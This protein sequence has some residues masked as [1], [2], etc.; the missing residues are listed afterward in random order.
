MASKT[1]DV[2]ARGRWKIVIDQVSQ[3]LTNNTSKVRVRGIMYNDGSGTSADSTGNCKRSISGTNGWS[4]SSVNFSVSGGGSHTLIDRE[5]TVTHDNDGTKQVTYTAKFGPTITSTFGSGGSVTLSMF[6]TRIPR[7]PG[8]PTNLQTVF[9]AP[10]R[11]NI[12]WG[13]APDNGSPVTEYHI[14]YADNPGF[15]PSSTKVVGNVL[16]T[17]VEG[18]T[19]GKTWYFKVIPKSDLDW[20]EWSATVSRAVPN[21]PS[22]M[23]APGVTLGTLQATATFT[24]PANGGATINGYDIQ[25]GDNTAFTG[26]KLFSTTS[27]PYTITDLFVGSVNYVRV[28]AKNSQGVGAWSPYTTTALVVGGP[29]VRH[30]GVWKYT[31]CYVRQA[32]VW[33]IATPYV[34]QGGVWKLAGG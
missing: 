18:L 30:A 5:F 6:L 7:G 28:R 8:A 4:D 15:V 9:V 3:N 2:G 13:A 14:R 27:S 17:F 25:V 32:G 22:T 20:G 34:K 24:A 23:T 19:I 26:A 33:K 29:L 21:V 16:S 31:I 10:R 1:I 11:M 12:S